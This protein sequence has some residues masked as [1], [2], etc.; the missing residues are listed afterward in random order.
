M[1]LDLFDNPSIAAVDKFFKTTRP[2]LFDDLL[3]ITDRELVLIQ[4][5][6]P[7]GHQGIVIGHFTGGDL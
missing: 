2:H 4:N 7:P 6:Q 1:R 5:R 3:N